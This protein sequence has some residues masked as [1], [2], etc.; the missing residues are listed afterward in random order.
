MRREQREIICRVIGNLQML[1]AF[2]VGAES[3]SMADCLSVAIGALFE[4]IDDDGISQDVC[5]PATLTFTC[6]APE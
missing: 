2:L 4:L 5:S 6:K 1:R 3:Q